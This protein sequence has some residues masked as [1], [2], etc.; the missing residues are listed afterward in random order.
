MKIFKKENSQLGVRKT[1]SLTVLQKL[2]LKKQWQVVVQMLIKW[3]HFTQTQLNRK[4]LKL[5]IQNPHICGDFVFRI[6]FW[7]IIF[8]L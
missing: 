7:L 2:V 4:E 8:I 5:N 3:Q 1:A 6:Y